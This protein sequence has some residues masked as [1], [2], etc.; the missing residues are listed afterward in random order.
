M[1]LKTIGYAIGVLALALSSQVMAG[2]KHHD[3]NDKA[4]DVITHQGLTRIGSP[5]TYIDGTTS[6]VRTSEGVSLTANTR[7]LNPGYAYTLWLMTFENPENCAVPCECRVPD[8]A[9][10]DVGLGV[11]WTAGRVADSNGQIVLNSHVNY[12]EIPQGENQVLLPVGAE[13]KA[14][15]KLVVRE[16]GLAL[17]NPDMLDQQLSS[18]SLTCTGNECFDALLSTHSSP[19]CKVPRSKKH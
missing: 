13:K 19:F 4:F 18:H 5:E 16:H 10:P 9:N 3:G 14:E 8:G 7:G 12:G 1:K 11:F 15:F 6:I 17:T 2:G